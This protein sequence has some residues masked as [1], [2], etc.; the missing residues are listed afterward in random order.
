VSDQVLTFTYI[1]VTTYSD[2]PLLSAKL[3]GG[4]SEM[5][6]K[7]KIIR[8]KVGLVRLSETLGNVSQVCKVMGYSRAS[9]YGF[10]E[11]Y[12]LINS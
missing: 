3:R 10:K 6:N 2:T 9:F 1:I 7:Q 12:V 8:N 5:T 4:V 11:L